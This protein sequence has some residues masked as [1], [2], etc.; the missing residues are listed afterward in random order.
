MDE[1]D[2][3]FQTRK[4]P[5]KEG[6]SPLSLLTMPAPGQVQVLSWLMRRPTGATLLEIQEAM[7]GQKFDI[8]KVL[9]DLREEGRIQAAVLEGEVYYRVQIRTR[10]KART[11]SEQINQMWS[12]LDQDK[13]RFVRSLPLFADLTAEEIA[14][15]AELIDRKSVV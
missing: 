1:L 3:L 8:P 11:P 14:D 9:H 6:L 5:R 10:N 2:T 12:R 13:V 4:P 15:V 7:Q